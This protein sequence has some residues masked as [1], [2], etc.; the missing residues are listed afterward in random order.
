M[1]FKAATALVT[2]LAITSAAPSIIESR[3]FDEYYVIP[4]VKL[5]GSPLDGKSIVAQNGN[6]FINRE[7]ATTTCVVTAPC[8]TLSNRTMIIFSNANYTAKLNSY[9]PGGQIVY[10]SSTGQ[11]Q[12]LP[13]HSTKLPEGAI[14]QSF[15][16]TEFF[17]TGSSAYAGIIWKGRNWVACPVAGKTGVFQIQTA[18]IGHRS[19]CVD[20]HVE[21]LELGGDKTPQAYEYI[22]P[23]GV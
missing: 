17:P 14:A 7:K 1:L 2:L 15:I 9:V 18:A 22:S 19:E 12:Y 21:A 13:T 20:I 8:D 11:F 16:R 4:T 5:P 3:Q 6:F 23:Y 10:I